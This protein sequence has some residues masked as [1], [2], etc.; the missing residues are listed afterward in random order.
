MRA[1]IRKLERELNDLITLEREN[2]DFETYSVDIYRIKKQLKKL[3]NSEYSKRKDL[4]R[5]SY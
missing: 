3:Y 1:R 2:F 5:L 4:N